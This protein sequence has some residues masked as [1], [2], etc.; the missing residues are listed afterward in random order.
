MRRFVR[1]TLLSARDLAFTAGPFLALA[2]ALLAGAYFLLKPTPPKRVVLATG[3]EQS[4]YAEFGRR[5]AAELKRYGIEVVLR[6]SDG[7]SQNRRLLRDVAENVDLGFVRGG[8]G[9]ALFAVDEEQKGVPLL[10][11]GSLFFEPV[12]LFYHEAAAQKLPAKTLAPLTS[13]QHLRVNTGPRG[14]GATNILSKLLD[15]NGVD[16][17]A[18]RFD[19]RALTPGVV[20]FLGGELDAI[21]LV[22]APESPI[23]QMLLRTPGV[24][25][26]EFAHAEAY[27]R[28]YAFLSPVVLPRGV[29]NIALDVPPADVRLVAPTAMLVAR[30]GTH[31][32]LLE[33]F[34]QA[35]HRIHGVGGWFN[36]A[37]EFPSPQNVEYPLAREAERYYKSGPLLLQR[38]LPFW[39][40]NLIDRMWVALVSIVAV[41]IPLARVLPPLYE[42]R[43]RSRVF[44]WYRHLRQIEDDLARGGSPSSELLSELDKLDLRVERVAVPLSYAD[45]LYAL[46]GHIALVRERLRASAG[47]AGGPSVP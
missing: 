40:A 8:S 23:V 2:A 4:D 42:F 34:M 28:R 33:L 13:L 17:K 24:R 26:F 19:R 11:L 27:A 25:L 46:R 22:S 10:A 6:A 31:P 41:L 5:Y 15:A 9:E 20:A 1:D 47:K 14:S 7:S 16:P 39:L 37:R 36:R 45:E 30:D 12:W 32:A 35:A 44:R 38:Y 18:L 29:V 3:P 43:I 21:T